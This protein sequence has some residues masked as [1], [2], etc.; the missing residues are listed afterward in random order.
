MTS[1][2]TQ[3]RFWYIWGCQRFWSEAE[4]IVVTV[5]KY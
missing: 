3:T 1:R 2:S 4:T 5:G